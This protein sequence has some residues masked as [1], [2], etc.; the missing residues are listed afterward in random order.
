MDFPL[1]VL[2]S[3]PHSKA[4]DYIKGTAITSKSSVLGH[5]LYLLHYT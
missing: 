3:T 4:N 2:G 5:M 1:L